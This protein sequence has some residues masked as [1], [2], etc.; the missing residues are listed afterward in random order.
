MISF[1]MPG[2]LVCT[3][4]TRREFPTPLNNANESDIERL[5]VESLYFS[6]MQWD[7][8][9]KRRD[10]QPFCAVECSRNGSVRVSIGMI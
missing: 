5:R 8:W 4:H 1:P 6:P 2:L 7:D 10:L 3:T 9:L